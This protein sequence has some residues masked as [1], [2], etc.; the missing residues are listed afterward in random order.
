MS[1]RTITV[2]SLGG[3]VQS[4]TLA[5]MAA[6]GVLTPMPI[7]AVFADTHSEPAAVYRHLAKLAGHLPFPV[8][9]VSAG[10]L[11]ADLLATMRGERGRMEA[12]P[13]F[14]TSRGGMVQRQC[15]RYYK[16][17]PVQR[18]IREL[19][20]L[21]S[22]QRWPKDVRCHQWIGISLDEAHRMKPSGVPSIENVYPLVDAR[23]TRADCLRWLELN[24]YERPPKSACTFCPYHDDA[25]WRALRDSAPA[26]WADAVRVD[27]AIRGGV[28]G[29]RRPGGEAWFVHRSRVP[30]SQADLSTP[31][32]RGQANLF[33][34]E[35]EGMCGV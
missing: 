20:G 24:G 32:E 1:S 29:P 15:T 2:L 8:A 4:T 25:Q 5:L 17:R 26:D 12:R 14:F 27:E 31:E 3:G 21:K 35:C 23:L 28:P 6:R 22:G 10:D 13:P 30:L 18:R 7:E 33:G 11:R 16:I 34:N 19:L 9:R